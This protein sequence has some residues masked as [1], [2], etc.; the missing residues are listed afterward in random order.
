MVPAGALISCRTGHY[1]FIYEKANNGI[2]IGFKRL[3]K[4]YSRLT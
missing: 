3:Y 1:E 2:F 4:G